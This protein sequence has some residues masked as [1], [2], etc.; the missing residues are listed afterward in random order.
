[1]KGIYRLIGTIAAACGACGIGHA[2]PANDHWAD[3]M[4][5]TEL[6]FSAT[7]PDVTTASTD[8]TDP[9]LFCWWQ[10]FHPASPGDYGLWFGFVTGDT[11]E[12]VDIDTG[13]YDTALAVY[14]GEPGAFV[15]VPGGCN[16]DGAGIGSGSILRG[17][18]LRANTAY[19]IFVAAYVFVADDASLEFSMSRSA[20]HRVTKTEDGDDG[21]CDET[22]CSL[23]EAVNRS[24][25]EPG[26][27]VVPAG[28]YLVPGG[29]DFGAHHPGGMNLYGAGMG[30]TVIDASADGRV[31]TFPSQ[32]DTLQILTW[33]LHD[34]TLTNGSTAESGGAVFAYHGYVAFERV[35]VTD[36]VASGNGGGVAV[37]FGA[38]S[39][40]RSLVAGNRA[41]GM[42]GGAYV[43]R[44]NLEVRESTFTVN[45]AGKAEA[46]GGGGLA[47]T[48]LYD[49]QLFNA[50]VSA[51]RSR[52][53]AGGLYAQDIE[54]G[55][56]K[57]VSIVGNTF[58]E[59]APDAKGGGLWIGPVD[60]MSLF[61]SV[62]AGNHVFG[63]P[64]TPS[65]CEQDEQHDLVAID[66]LVQVPGSCTVS[67]AY[68][69]VGVDPLLSPLGLYDS[70]LPVHLPLAGSPL[71]DAGDVS[72]TNCA[73]NDARGIARPQDG[74][75]DG[76]ATCDIGAVEVEAPDDI[77]YS[78]GFD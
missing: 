65:D 66:N 39:F 51:N 8:D 46:R 29:L 30:E 49:L 24:T 34:L 42:G 6:P 55:V 1:M 3:R 43:Q 32:D 64:E 45:D 69:L 67:A 53:S 11:D 73:R 18:K 19:S 9:D 22:D 75:G 59:L 27:I 76:I 56:L 5:I 4:A 25:A 70:A 26:A 10:S 52:T 61:N 20:V 2:V 50:T 47:V 21:Q 71:V 35:A 31:M 17:V 58:R 63:H 33:G 7:V 74:D 62:L 37:H 77:I 57:N 13:G 16:D 44:Y 40:I 28:R 41:A 38:A 14:E 54:N 12:Y 48:G 60:R 78:D 36:S 23:R 68:N 72:G 15:D